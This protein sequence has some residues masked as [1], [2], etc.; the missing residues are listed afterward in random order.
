MRAY[1]PEPLVNHES[2]SGSAPTLT[3]VR[4]SD[5]KQAGRRIEIVFMPPKICEG[6]LREREAVG[7]G[8]HVGEF[9]MNDHVAGRKAGAPGHTFIST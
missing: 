5:A 1:L 6:T 2:T 8:I 9:Q 3:A 4:I 7:A